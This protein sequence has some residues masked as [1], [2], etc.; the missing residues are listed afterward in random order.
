MSGMGGRPSCLGQDCL[1]DPLTVGILHLG[2]GIGSRRFSRP[3]HYTR[4]ATGSN[5]PLPQPLS[6]KAFLIY[7]LGPSAWATSI[8]PAVQRRE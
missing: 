4:G 8:E 6:P 5:P 2:H 1:N 3:G 7:Q